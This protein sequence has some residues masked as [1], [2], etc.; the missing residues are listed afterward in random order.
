MASNPGSATSAESPDGCNELPRPRH[1][2]DDPPGEDTSGLG[3]ALDQDQRDRARQMWQLGD[4]PAVAARLVPAARAVSAAVGPG[5]GRA[6]LD[7]AAGTGS[8]ALA[9]AGSGWE[10]HAVDIAPR[11]IEAGRCR[12]RSLGHDIRWREA[13]MDDLPY[14]SEAFDL[15]ASSFGLIFAAEPAV[16]LAES[17]RV[18]RPGGTLAFSAWTPQGFM[19]QMT[20]R[21]AELL[22]AQDLMAGPFR[23]GDSGVTAPW[24]QEGFTRVCT[25]VHTLPW[26]FPSARVAT[27]FLFERS[28]GHL[29]ALGLAG[30]R[31]AELVSAVTELI[32]SLASPDGSI[33]IP[34]QYVVTT[35]QRRDQS[36]K[37][38]R[39]GRTSGG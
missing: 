38:T 30:P 10:V 32:Q 21:M 11:L 19:G 2:P 35:A 9:L 1:Q 37:V 36:L 29:A 20:A 18:L 27:D 13:S 16:T 14:A 25:Q 6:A 4:Y 39:G 5:R 3:A 28:P 31:G 7:V 24:L 8:L 22:S 15:V 34:A 23:W 17:H 12:A 26:V 33:D